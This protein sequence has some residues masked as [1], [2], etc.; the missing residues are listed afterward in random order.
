[1]TGP[2]TY[3]PMFKARHYE[4]H[5]L[6]KG[7]ESKGGNSGKVGGLKGRPTAMMER[8]DRVEGRKV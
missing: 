6:S 8:L 7:G 5:D 3:R 1:M 2:I 4:P